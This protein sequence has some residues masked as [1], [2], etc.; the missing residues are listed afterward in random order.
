MKR[1]IIPQLSQEE[2]IEFNCK[3]CEALGIANVIREMMEK[4]LQEDLEI[5][6]KRN[7][8][9]ALHDESR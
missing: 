3:G 5:E 4:D 9:K 6:A 2:K 8:K 7:K 1:T